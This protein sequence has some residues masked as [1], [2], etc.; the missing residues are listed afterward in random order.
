MLQLHYGDNSVMLW[1]NY[2]C[3]IAGYRNQLWGVLHYLVELVLREVT[4]G[5]IAYGGLHVT[6]YVFP[7]VYNWP[8]H[9]QNEFL[10]L[11][12]SGSIWKLSNQNPRVVK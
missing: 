7:D 2:R 11:G 10:S 5:H 4:V 6:E 8:L 9:Q 12:A 3:I 1:I